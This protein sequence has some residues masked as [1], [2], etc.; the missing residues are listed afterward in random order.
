MKIIKPLFIAISILL[1]PAIFADN[2]S[3]ESGEKLFKTHC[4]AC[5]GANVGGMD[6]SKRIAPPIAAVRLH[7]IGTYPDQDSFVK[8]VSAWVEKQDASKSLMRGAINKFNIMPPIIIPK[9]DAEKIAAYIYAGDIEKPKG[10]RGL[11]KM[12]GMGKGMHNLAIHQPIQGKDMGKMQRGGINEMMR[13]LNLSPQQKQQIQML[14]QKKQQ[15]LRPLKIEMQRLRQTTQQLD[16][17]NPNYK[18]QMFALAE[19]KSKLVYQ[20][21]IQKSEIR[22]KIESI[23]TPEQYSKFSQLR[24][25]H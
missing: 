24:K 23:L 15:I 8:A 5:H 3:H 11:K 2:D 12:Q 25:K 19:K 1:S 4:A 21:A 7:Y 14:I 20:M 13:Q 18:K 10:F 16:T 17:T 22:M 6:M 9:E